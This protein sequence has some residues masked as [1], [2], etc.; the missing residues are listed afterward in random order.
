MKIEQA[1]KALPPAARME[2]LDFVAFFEQKYSKKIPGCER[3]RYLL[4]GAR[5]IITPQD[6]GQ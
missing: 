6:M 5:R 1:I 4:G 3:R 2:V